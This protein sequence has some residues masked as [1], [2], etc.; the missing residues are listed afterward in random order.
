MMNKFGIFTR[1]R[2]AIIAAS[3][4]VFSLSFTLVTY[5]SQNANLYCPNR[6]NS[7]SIIGNSGFLDVKEIW[8]GGGIN[9]G[10]HEFLLRQDSVGSFTVRYQSVTSMYLNVTNN[11]TNDEIMMTNTTEQIIKNFYHKTPIEFF[12]SGKSVWRIEQGGRN[13]TYVPDFKEVGIEYN[14]SEAK[15]MPDDSIQVTYVVLAAREA[16]N[17]TYLIGIPDACPGELVTVGDSFH[18]G[19]L[20][21]DK[22]LLF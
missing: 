17:G 6:M 5:A 13:L 14:V 16:L 7:A 11:N 9:P 10:M 2:L 21:W 1:R 8:R 15:V 3:A 4:A 18:S 19:P 20:P 12:D 22:G